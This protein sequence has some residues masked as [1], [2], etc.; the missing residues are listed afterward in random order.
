MRKV[1][2]LSNSELV[3]EWEETILGCWNL[4]QHNLSEEAVT[5]QY[6]H[7]NI[8]DPRFVFG[9]DNFRICSVAAAYCYDTLHVT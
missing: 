4:F 5:N 8:V 2:V 3:S 6:N 7:A 1:K 9:M